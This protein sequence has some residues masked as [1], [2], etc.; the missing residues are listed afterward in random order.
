M[1]RTGSLPARQLRAA[2]FEL[3]VRPTCEHDHLVVSG[4]VRLDVHETINLLAHVK[5]LSL[6]MSQLPSCETAGRYPAP[7]QSLR[8]AGLRQSIWARTRP[9]YSWR[10]SRTDR[11]PRFIVNRGSPASARGSTSAGVFC[12]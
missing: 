6:P 12:P 2:P 3:P 5:L 9:A 11:S 4:V 8:W 10:T 7:V 1:W